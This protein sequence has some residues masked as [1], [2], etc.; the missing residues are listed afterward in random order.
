MVDFLFAMFNAILGLFIMAFSI[1]WIPLTYIVQFIHFL[2]RK[3]LGLD[4]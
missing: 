2:W 1:V 3:L 4:T